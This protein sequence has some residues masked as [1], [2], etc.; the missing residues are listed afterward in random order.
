MELRC[1]AK[2]GGVAVVAIATLASALAPAG[3]VGEAA[4]G[5]APRPAVRTLAVEP[6]VRGGASSTARSGALEWE[7]WATR[8]NLVPAWVRRRAATATI[9]VVDSGADRRAPDLASK[10]AGMAS[11]VDFGA[12]DASGH[13]T[14]VAALAAGSDSNRV[15]IAGFGGAARLLLVRAVAHDGTI[16]D[17]AEAAAIRY[18]VD[19]GARIVNL[20]LAGSTTSPT[21]RDAIEYAVSRGVLLVAAAGNDYRRGNRVQYPAA[22]LQPEGS[23][24]VGGSGLVVAASTRSGRRAAFSGTGTWISMAAP[25]ERVVSATSASASRRDYRRVRIPGSGRGVY[26]VASGTSFAAPQVAG[27][28][29]LV[30]AANP[31]LTAAGVADVLKRTAAGSRRGW[32]PELGWGVL[33]VGAAVAEAIRTRPASA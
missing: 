2:L 21:E 33:D 22:L 19:N 8:T 26:A 13:G 25:G 15:G 4:S 32:S 18:A 1:A 20:S 14:F 29:A 28:A 16:S 7:Y 3:S 5:S 10:I 23:R 9:G 31:A 24:G 27:A 30:W 11:V 12:G 6:A 17:A